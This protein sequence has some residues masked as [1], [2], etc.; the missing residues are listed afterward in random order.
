MPA[1]LWQYFTSPEQSSPDPGVLPPH[2]YGVP[3]QLLAALTITLAALALLVLD[4]PELLELDPEPV[5][6]F[7]VLLPLL[8]VPLLE[9]PLLELPLLEL[10][11][12][13]VVFPEDEPEDVLLF[14]FPDEPDWLEVVLELEELS[15]AAAA[16]SSCAFL[17]AS[18]SAFLLASSSAA[19]CAI[20]A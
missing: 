17:R 7:D 12:L 13:D 6:G 3:R 14:W 18:S 20:A 10:P 5:L 15:A 9:L 4:P 11:L 2:T 8:D 19:A 16:A 1:T